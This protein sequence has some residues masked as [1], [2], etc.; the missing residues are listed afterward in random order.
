MIR[1][2]GHRE[3][4]SD[5]TKLSGHLPVCA[6][7]FQSNLPM[8]AWLLWLVAVL[9][10]ATPV[11][12][13]EMPG[14][15]ANVVK[16]FEILSEEGVQGL[17]HP[18]SSEYEPMFP[19]CARSRRT[20][21]D[22]YPLLGHA[23]T[24]TQG[25]S[26]LFYV[27]NGLLALAC[28]SMAALAAGLTMGLLSLDPLM[29]RIKMRAGSTEAEKKQAEK[30]LDI[31]QQ[32]HLL[33]VTLLLMNS[34][35]NEALPLF[36]DQIVPSY[37]AVILS[38][39]L[40]LFFGEIIPSAV[41][42]GPNQM[43]IASM[44]A[45]LVRAVMCLLFPLAFPI[46]KLL[47]IVLHEDENSSRFN[48]GELSALVRIQYE[49]RLAAKKHRRAEK[50]RLRDVT[51]EK[52]SGVL[53]DFSEGRRDFRLAEAVKA[54]KQEMARISSEFVESS[55]S[56]PSVSLE[57]ETKTLR[58]KLQKQKSVHV[59]EVKM[60]EGALLM[61]TK[62]AIDAYTPLR[63][64]FAINFETVLDERHIVKIYSSGFSR[65]PVFK[66]KVGRENDIS[67][68]CGILMT[69]QLIVVNASDHRSVSTLPL[70]IP[71]CV[72]PSM[73]LIE[74]T[75]WFQTGGTGNKGGHM[76]IVC[77]KPKVAEEAL[78]NGEA[79]PE[80][81]GVMGIITL[82]DILEDLIQEEIFDETD[83]L[84]FV[85]ARLARW[86][87]QRWK[88]F[89]QKQRYSRRVE[90]DRVA[91]IEEG[92]GSPADSTPLLSRKSKAERSSFLGIF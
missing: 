27:K 15:S 71:F 47:D 10:L 24:Q 60:V 32:H 70:N 49:E 3:A 4:N 72:P 56:L 43:K 5:I 82:E 30:L 9:T 57:P 64:V 58:R 76:A 38:V 75:N 77:A 41:F 88:G 92:R 73:D 31:V 81:A 8:A 20:A 69:K 74:L 29:L 6:K 52:E 40:V 85:Q 21:Q 39:T 78:D 26:T 91:S 16:A 51:R 18:S 62:T 35:A 34:M 90:A 45:P 25:G 50:R 33:L 2:C 67:A 55:S 12:S 36:L 42:T 87:F 14:Q 61:K 13:D 66:K 79:I 65:V 23:M 44:L 17:C 7:N 37:V 80:R 48:R 28:V 86:A 84:N 53:N 59:D 46:A 63:N 83:G 68:I 19:R 11:L 89:V 22:E 1:R 54:H